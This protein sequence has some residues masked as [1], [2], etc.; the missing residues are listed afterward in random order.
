MRIAPAI[1]LTPKEK[2]K[3]ESAK[4]ARSSALRLRERAAIVLLA[5][6]GLENKA[7][8][9]QLRQDVG[10]VSRWRKRYAEGGMDAIIKDKTRPGRIPALPKALRAEVIRRT[11]EEK[12]GAATHW[13]RALLAAQ[14]GVSA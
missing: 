5:A 4:Q 1:Q 2:A 7:I 10:K 11:V 8:A 6:A 3:L 14:M 13:S 9:A 12:P